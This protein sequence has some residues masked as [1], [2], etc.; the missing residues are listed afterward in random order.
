MRIMT[1]PVGNSTQEMCV[2]CGVDYAK[3]EIENTDKIV[4]L[5]CRHFYHINCIS[6][7]IE[8]R[9][10]EK[11]DLSCCFCNQVFVH[12]P[13]RM[14][15]LSNKED[16][17]HL[18]EHAKET[19]IFKKDINSINYILSHED[20]FNEI[21]NTIASFTN[22]MVNHDSLPI[23]ELGLIFSNDLTKCVN[24]YT[25]HNVELSL[26]LLETMH[27]VF[28]LASRGIIPPLPTVLRMRQWENVPFI[29]WPTELKKTGIYI[30]I[31]L[32]NEKK[33]PM[34]I[35]AE[36]FKRMI[37][38]QKKEAVLSRLDKNLKEINSSDSSI[39]KTA[40]VFFG[41]TAIYFLSK[42]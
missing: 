5:A 33:I 32:D 18:L 35:S 28:R 11:K 39:M 31:T 16:F 41:L 10:S 24:K 3:N 2:V 19:S 23:D 27:V 38:Q 40:G 22:S 17:I 9:I 7:W 42:R 21:Y 15:F 1:I 29:Y 34:R 4:E 26:N 13:M 25:C 36:H 30:N 14:S 37:F 6:N 12:N 20:L 8:H